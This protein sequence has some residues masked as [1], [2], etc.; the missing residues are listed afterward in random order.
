MNELIVENI[1]CICCGSNN[2]ETLVINKKDP[3]AKRLYSDKVRARFVVCKTCGFVYQNP[4]LVS[5]EIYDKDYRLKSPEEIDTE[6]I[7]TI[8]LQQFKWIEEF[9]S[10]TFVENRSTK[11]IL[12]IGCRSGYLLKLFHAKGYNVFGIEPDINF[13]EYVKEKYGLNVKPSYL[14]AQI[15]EDIM[16]DL[17]IASH[18][19]EHVPNLFDFLSVVRVKLKDNGCFFL[20]IPN[21]KRPGKLRLWASFF[22]IQHLYVFSLNTLSI[23]LSKAGFQV[24][25]YNDDAPKGLCLL[26]KKGEYREVFDYVQEG[27]N[28]KAICKTIA[29]H[30]YICPFL[31]LK[32]NK[33]SVLL[34]R[35][36]TGLLIRILGDAKGRKIIA[37]IKMRFS[38]R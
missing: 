16:F 26:A 28:Y 37:H 14:N 21:I 6:E 24:L 3:F 29:I 8:V 10:D 38:N 2:Y 33:L 27:D 13:A 20:D 23:I 22:S 25:K 9:V 31:N 32:K 17:I 30:R 35:F 7:P 11:Q 15:F 12:D 18:V 4:R 5:S 36:S 19:L 1:N 34:K